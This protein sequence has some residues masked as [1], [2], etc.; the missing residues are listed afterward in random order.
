MAQDKYYRFEMNF[1]DQTGPAAVD[2]KYNSSIYTNKAMDSSEIRY[3]AEQVGA[4]S[5]IDLTVNCPVG[6]QLNTNS[7]F[8]G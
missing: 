8:G 3:P 6:Y 7:P 4:V 1:Y 5:T 2:L